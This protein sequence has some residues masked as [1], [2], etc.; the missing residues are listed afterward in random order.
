M[1]KQYPVL[2]KKLVK[3]PFMWEIGHNTGTNTN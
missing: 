1:I 3:L 2:W